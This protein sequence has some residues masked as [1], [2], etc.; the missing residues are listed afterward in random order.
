MRCERSSPGERVQLLGYVDDDVLVDELC[1]CDCVLL[2][3]RQEAFGLTLV[4]AMASGAPIV[5]SDIPA[6]RELAG[7]A[8][9]ALADFDDP[10]AIVR[11]IEKQRR[12]MTRTVSVLERR[13]CRA[14]R[15]S[16]H[17]RCYEEVGDASPAP[18]LDGARVLGVDVQPMEQSDIL[19]AVQEALR[20]GAGPVVDRPS[21]PTT[22]ST[23][24]PCI[25]GT[26]CSDASTSSPS[27]SSSTACRWSGSAGSQ[28]NTWADATGRHGSI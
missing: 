3:S 20:G 25:A 5:A 2:P 11:A 9:I 10:Q 21:S 16:T 24:P 8:G 26:H 12:A 14:A 23:A 18:G 19:R 27:T 6:Y 17:A 22:T 1:G 15:R 7:G 13:S 4:E 28:D